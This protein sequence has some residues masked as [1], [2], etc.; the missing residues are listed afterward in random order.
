MFQETNQG[1]IIKVKVIPNAHRSEMIGWEND[2]LKCRLA[3]V[4]EKGQANDELLQFLASYL[5]IK[6]SSIKL[7]QGQT[8]RHKRICIQGISLESI[9]SLLA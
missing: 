4:P 9:K 3:A 2:V 5:K 7:L 1:I 8:N 6:K